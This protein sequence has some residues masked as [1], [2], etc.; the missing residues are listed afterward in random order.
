LLISLIATWRKIL[1]LR[2]RRRRHHDTNP[3][4]TD[5][6][7][8]TGDAARCPILLPAATVIIATTGWPGRPW[9]LR[10]LSLIQTCSRSL[11]SSGEATED[12]VCLRHH[13]PTCSSR[14]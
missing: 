11:D 2:H 12:Q 1:E 3:I 10:P 4:N 14:R 7:E 8:R 13:L 9:T 6:L 5:R